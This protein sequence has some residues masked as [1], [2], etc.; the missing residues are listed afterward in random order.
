MPVA[1]KEN[2][3]FKLN[4]LPEAD[5]WNAL[6]FAIK[7]DTKGKP[8]PTRWPK[9]NEPLVLPLTLKTDKRV[10]FSDKEFSKLHTIYQQSP[11]AEAGPTRCISTPVL[12]DVQRDL[13]LARVDRRHQRNMKKK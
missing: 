11:A 3:I 12:R 8:Y 1:L 5:Y 6:G 2:D 10:D 13:K 4:E 9:L 7:L